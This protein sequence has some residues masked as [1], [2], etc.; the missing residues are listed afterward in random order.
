MAQE[1]DPKIVGLFCTWCTYTGADLAGTSRL[2]YP[3]NV[4]GVRVM[5]SG[6]VD[7]QFVLDAFRHGA[8]GV[9]VG[10]CHPGD[11]HYQEGNYKTLR[12]ITLL[13]KVLAQMNLNPE[14]L[15]LEWISASEA[16]KFA[17]TVTDFT[18]KIRELGPI[19][20]GAEDPAV[21]KE[22]VHA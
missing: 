12:R 2:K 20:A 11:C 7:P 14:R 21:A 9:L 6:R 17:R 18:R 22:E 15:R 8:D 16:Q 13:K 19:P 1:F 3:P 10:G 4:R 5:C